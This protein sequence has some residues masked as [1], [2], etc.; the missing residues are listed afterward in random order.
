[1]NYTVIRSDELSH[2]GVLGMKW[3]IRRYQNSDGSLTPAGEKRYGKKYSERQKLITMYE[4]RASK[5]EKSAELGEKL[6]SDIKQKILSGDKKTINDF[7]KESYGHDDPKAIGFKNKEDAVLT[8]IASW[9]SDIKATRDYAK[10]YRKEAEKIAKTP[11]N[12][13]TKDELRV[14]EKGA[15]KLG[16]AL[17]LVGSVAFANVLKRSGEENA[18][19]YA[20]GMGLMGQLGFMAITNA[21]TETTDKSHD[22][23][24][25]K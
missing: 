4:N 3:G 21:I 23:Y 25:K 20:A 12:K 6:S 7:Y 14:I 13:L 1:M 2:H 9:E 19:L 15:N 22:R 17:N 16:L 10:K 11:I 8:S 5:N 18:L 24:L